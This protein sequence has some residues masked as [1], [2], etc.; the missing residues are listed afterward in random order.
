MSCSGGFEPDGQG[1]PTRR[2]WQCL[3]A[4]IRA[5]KS[6]CF[7]ADY[8][9]ARLDD[10]GQISELARQVLVHVPDYSPGLHASCLMSLTMPST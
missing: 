10:V 1:F 3:S 4:E 6:I 8:Q 9:H 7:V 2:S 5:F